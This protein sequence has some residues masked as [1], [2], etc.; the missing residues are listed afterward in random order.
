MHFAKASSRRMAATQIRDSY[1]KKANN[2]LDW[3][4]ANIVNGFPKTLAYLKSSE[5][6][7]LMS[8]KKHIQMLKA[9]FVFVSY[10]QTSD[11]I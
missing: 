10:T 7:F 4:Y 3:L 8:I 1:K 6:T 5:S 2:R 9:D 11:E